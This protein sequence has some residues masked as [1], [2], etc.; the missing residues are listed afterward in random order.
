MSDSFE[1]NYAELE[2]IISRL[3]YASDDLGGARRTAPTDAPAG[4]GGAAAAAMVAHLLR[5]ASTLCQGLEGAIAGVTQT[6]DDYRLVDQR[7]ADRG[8]RIMEPQ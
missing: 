5:S 8:V 1:V 7:V 2:A 6:R 3:G 4:V